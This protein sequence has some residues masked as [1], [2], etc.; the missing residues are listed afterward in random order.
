MARYR[1]SKL[2]VVTLFWIASAL[3]PT[4]LR[5]EDNPPAFCV[6][7][8]SGKN[9]ALVVGTDDYSIFGGIDS[10][11]NARNDAALIGEVLSKQGFSVR[12]LLNPSRLT[13]NEELTKLHTYLTSIQHQQAV[14]ALVYVAGHGFR[15]PKTRVDYILLRPETQRP[16]GIRDLSTAGGRIE[17]GRKDVATIVN[18]FSAPNSVSYLF[19]FDSCRG[20]FDIPSGTITVRGEGYGDAQNVIIRNPTTD[21]RV[22]V[23]SS[24]AGGFAADNV[25]NSAQANGLYASVFAEF[26]RIPGIQTGKILALTNFIVAAHPANQKPT[27]YLHVGFSLYNDWYSKPNPTLCELYDSLLWSRNPCPDVSD[28][29][30][31]KADVCP[32]LLSAG[33][34]TPQAR[35]C[36]AP[37]AKKWFRLDYAAICQNVAINDQ[38]R[39]F[40]VAQADTLVNRPNVQVAIDGFVANQRVA[41]EMA[42]GTNMIV[43][44]DVERQL[45]DAPP[46]L[47]KNIT[48]QLRTELIVKSM[49]PDLVTK[50]VPSP[51]GLEVPKGGVVIR[52]LPT[53]QSDPIKTFKPKDGKIDID[54]QI[55]Q[56]DQDLVGV[57]VNDGNKITLGWVEWKDIQRNIFANDVLF[58]EYNASQVSPEPASISAIIDKLRKDGA[59]KF[60]RKIQLLIWRGPRSEGPQAV[61][62]AARLH[63]LTGLLTQAGVKEADVLATMIESETT[64]PPAIVYFGPPT[65]IPFEPD[66]LVAK[67]PGALRRGG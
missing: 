45:R 56:C 18:K 66:D 12:C 48:Q 55:L 28:I 67:N 42:P 8:Y 3:A 14:R 44:Q 59:P 21:E 5:A 16:D 47:R 20:L 39:G 4:F 60:R 63:Y 58:P 51:F 34:L 31:I 27:M 54:C 23:F 15:D 30:C 24:G 41:M 53:E 37:Y 62:A 2:A 7:D 50:N 57:R 46:A 26:L 43:R 19:I 11:K 32:K 40:S 61:L 6:T 52:T 64:Q 25:P 49:R 9:V 29:A 36:L 17:A 22:I 35:Q 38:N 65:D 1:A 10:L 33:P 13:F